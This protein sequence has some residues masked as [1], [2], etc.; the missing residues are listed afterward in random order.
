LFCLAC[1]AGSVWPADEPVGTI[2]PANTKLNWRYYAVSG[3]ACVMAGTAVSE[4]R[5][6]AFE[7]Q[8]RR[9]PGQKMKLF[10]IIPGLP[11]GGSLYMESPVTRERWKIFTESYVPALEGEKAEA[12]QR[13]VA[14]GV[15]LH[16]TFE[17][18]GTRVKYA[19]IS[20]GGP[21]AASR[22]QTCVVN[23]QQSFEAR[24]K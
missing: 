21:V 20:R 19:T 9:S 2:E 11:K 13:N 22:F 23:L 5:S 1:T 7:L 18:S 15:S 16:F 14:G 3:D 6:D 17:F 8:F 12:L 24:G 4:L 10:V